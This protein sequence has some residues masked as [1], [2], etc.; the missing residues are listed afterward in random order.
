MLK[1]TSRWLVRGLLVLAAVLFLLCIGLIHKE[2][3]T[4]FRLVHPGGAPSSTEVYGRWLELQTSEPCSWD[5]VM[6]WLQ[7]LGYRRVNGRPA[8]PGEFSAGFS[9]LT[10]F[11]RPFRYPDG[12]YPAQLV[13]LEFSSGRLKAI[14]ALAGN[15]SLASWRL[16]P[17]RLAEWDSGTKTAATPVRVAEL[18]PYV[19]RAVL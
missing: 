7:M 11:V 12:D 9:S 6:G 16:E 10:V 4:L 18:P 13:E 3:E 1:R 5:R 14:H 15:V 2:H 19:P 17:A 8:Q